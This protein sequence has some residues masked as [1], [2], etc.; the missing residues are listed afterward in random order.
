MCCSTTNNIPHPTTF[1]SIGEKIHHSEIAYDR[2]SKMLRPFLER[3]FGLVGGID[4]PNRFMVSRHYIRLSSIRDICH[5]EVAVA[6]MITPAA[7]IYIFIS[8]DFHKRRSQVFPK[9]L[10]GH[11]CV[12]SI[13]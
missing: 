10:A 11:K 7:R 1:G 6:T 9:Q 4:M 5:L 3:N 2:P 12:S 13:I 8:L